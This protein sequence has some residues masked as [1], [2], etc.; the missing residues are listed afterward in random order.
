MTDSSSLPTTNL[1]Q[2]YDDPGLKQTFA[3]YQRALARMTPEQLM[4]HSVELSARLQ[5]QTSRTLASLISG[6]LS[7]SL[8]SIDRLQVRSPLTGAQSPAPR[9]R[10][11]SH[12]QPFQRQ[13]TALDRL[14]ASNRPAQRIAA[15]LVAADIRRNQR[16]VDDGA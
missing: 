9:D 1:P 14:L 6:P 13:P 7:D 10:G 12:S 16:K 8:S 3:S 2:P 4:S 15:K 5:E 11:A